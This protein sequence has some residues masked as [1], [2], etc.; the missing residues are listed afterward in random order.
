MPF[1]LCIFHLLFKEGRRTVLGGLDRVFLLMVN[2]LKKV[3]CVD[4]LALL[5]ISD[6]HG[7]KH[8]NYGDQFKQVMLIPISFLQPAVNQIVAHT[9]QI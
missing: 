6:F 2:N 1:T 3:I 4:Y 9:G 8:A 7:R 5:T